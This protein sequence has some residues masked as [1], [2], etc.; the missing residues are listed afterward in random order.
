MTPFPTGSGGPLRSAF[1]ADPDMRELIDLFVEAMPDRVRSLRESLEHARLDDLRRLAHQ[2]R[3][4]AGS[5]GFAPVGDAAGRVED[6]LRNIAASD[7]SAVEQVK[8]AVDELVNLCR[9]VSP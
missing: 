6:Q 1:C 8:A 7:A 3:G 9:R 5:Y 2:L 4:A